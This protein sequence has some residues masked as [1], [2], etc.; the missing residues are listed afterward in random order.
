MTTRPPYRLH[1]SLGYQL[2]LAARL[3]ERRLDEGL[4]SLQLTRIT[5]CALLAI[6]NEELSQ[7]SDIAQFV[8]ID[9]TATS[10]ALRQMET[11]GLIARATG[12]GDGRTR[13]VALTDKG[14]ALLVQGTPLAIENNAIMEDRLNPQERETLIALLQKLH[15][16]EKISLAKI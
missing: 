15:A 13:R 4:K 6:G 1:A 8:G 3:Q 16:G 14:R 12:Q 10:R 2:S 5:W 11:A 7:P 9:R